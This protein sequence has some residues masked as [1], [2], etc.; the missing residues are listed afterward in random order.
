M[1][2]GSLLAVDSL[3]VDS[4]V[5]TGL[6]TLKNNFSFGGGITQVFV[7]TETYLINKL[8]PAQTT[9]DSSVNLKLY[10]VSTAPIRAITKYL[11]NLLLITRRK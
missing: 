2:R 3:W 10:D 11:N 5:S 7:P 4:V 6:F 8:S 9:N 1:S